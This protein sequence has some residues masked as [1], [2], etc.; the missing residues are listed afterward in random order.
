LGTIFSGNN[1]FGQF[2]LNLPKEK[3]EDNIISAELTKINEKKALCI[4][5]GSW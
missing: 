3:M 1:F 2:Q 5:T 4:K